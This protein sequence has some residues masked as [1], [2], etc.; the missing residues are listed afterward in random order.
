MQMIC[1]NSKQKKDF[2][3]GEFTLVS[4]N[5]GVLDSRICSELRAYARQNRGL[6]EGLDKKS[7]IEGAVESVLLGC[8]ID[9]AKHVDGGFAFELT[10]RVESMYDRCR[11]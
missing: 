5:A 10:K 4:L 11:N 6:G 2:D 3:C 8:K 9:A 7:V 1:A